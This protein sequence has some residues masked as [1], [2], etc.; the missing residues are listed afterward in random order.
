MPFWIRGRVMEDQEECTIFSLRK[1]IN[2][3]VEILNPLPR[4]TVIVKE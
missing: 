1:P 3:M 4:R 2:G